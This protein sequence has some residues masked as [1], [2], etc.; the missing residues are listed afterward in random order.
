VGQTYLLPLFKPVNDGSSN[1]ANYQ[2]G[3]GQG[4]NYYYSI[5]Q[6]VAIKVYYADNK[7]I[8]VKPQALIVTNSLLTGVTPAGPPTNTHTLSTT[9]AASK[10][11]Q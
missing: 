1:P 4:T 7:S 3:I 9:F 2:A 6:F 5:V 10:L 11:T 8:V